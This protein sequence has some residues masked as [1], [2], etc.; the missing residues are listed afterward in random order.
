MPQLANTE[1][2]LTLYC[3]CKNVH[4]QMLQP[5]SSACSVSCFSFASVLSFG[6]RYHKVIQSGGF[7]GQKTEA[8]HQIS[9]S[10][11]LK[12]L[13]GLSFFHSA[14]RVSPTIHQIH[15]PGP[16][17]CWLQNIQ[18]SLGRTHITQ[19]KWLSHT[20]ISV[21]LPFPH[22][23]EISTGNLWP[24][25]S[26]GSFLHKSSVFIIQGSCGPCCCSIHLTSLCRGTTQGLTHVA[27]GRRS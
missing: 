18:R 6:E 5:S 7:H 1:S 10:E 13:H 15:A 27:S 22:L 2:K 14:E 8:E 12:K 3:T 25:N 4:F 21:I 26:S 24:F 20:L 17:L 19:H 16:H 9:C 23:H 11:G